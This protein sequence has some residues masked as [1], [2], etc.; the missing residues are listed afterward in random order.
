VANGPMPRAAILIGSAALVAAAPASPAFAQVSTRGATYRIERAKG[1]ITIDGDLSDEGWRGALRIDRWYE[2]NPGDNT[3]PAVKNVGFLTYDDKFFYAG[4]EFEDPDPKQILAP[5]GDHDHIQ[6]NADFGGLF[7]DPRNEGHTA[8]EFQVTAHNV[9]FDAVLDDNGGG[10]NDSPDFFWQSAT[11]INDHGWTL[12]IRIPFSSLRYRRQDPQEWGVMLWRNYARDFRYQFTSVRQPRGSQC[13]ICRE[14][15]LTGL[16]GLPGGGHLVAAPYVAANRT[17]RPSGDLGTPLVNQPLEKKIGLDVKYTPNADNTLDATIRPDF[18]QIESDTAQISTNERFAL[19]YPE[20]RPFF[21]EGVELFSTPIQAVYTRT[22]TAPDWGGRA[23]GKLGGVSYTALVA[24][25]QGGGSVI[26][27]GPASSSLAPQDFESTVFIGRVKKDFGLSF[28]SALVTDRESGKDGHNRV[29]GPDAQFRFKGTETIT[30]QLLASDTK[31][32][33][34]PDVNPK[35]TGDTLRSAAGQVAWNHSTERFDASAAYKDFGSGFRADNGF[36]PQVGYREQR[37]EPGWTF[38]PQGFVSKARTFLIADRQ[39]ERDTGAVVFDS[40]NP[41]IGM[42]TRRSGFILLQYE[43]SHVR[44]QDALFGRH[45]F[46]W[47]ARIS[48]SRRVQTV[49]VDGFLGQEVDF[50]NVRPGR[51]GKV[52]VA[53]QVN[54]TDHLVFDLI[55]NT[56]WLHVD[57]ATGT[58]RPLFTAHVSRV[59]ANYTFTARSFVR[60]IGQYVSNARDSSLYLAPTSGHDGFFSGSALFAYKINW[61]SVMFFGYGD[62]RTLDEQRHLQQFDRQIFVKVSYAFQR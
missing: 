40:I 48:P 59:R 62:D 14:G 55:Y 25:D 53:A 50:E 28:V 8:Y 45:Q 51:G 6:S 15:T 30:G 11:H 17:A 56:T 33:N 60:L 23:T 47:Y 39:A 37:V 44:A 32:P 34:R 21:L 27:P 26:V 43:R 38:R 54:A 46:Q 61:Q 3:E 35:W 2:M 24:D 20:K 4:F 29:V 58:S 22:I 1:P 16:S 49:S 31:T 42:D 18:S 52:D 10:E 41:G 13:F 12:E 7:L 57:D 5:Y 9:Q 19:F 36:L